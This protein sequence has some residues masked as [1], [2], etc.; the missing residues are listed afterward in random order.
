MHKHSPT[1]NVGHFFN[2]AAE[3]LGLS[4]EMRRTLINPYREITVEIPLRRN[5]GEL[6]LYTGYR[7]QHNNFRGPFKG[8]IRYHDTADLDDVR[9]LASLMTWKTA[10]TNLPLG[11]AKGGVTCNPRNLETNELERLTRT[12]TDKIALV[13]G[14]R[15]DIPAPDMGTDSQTMAWLM[16]EY[17][18][19]HGH[20]PE[21]VTGKP[22]GLNGSFGRTEATG[23]G[24]ALVIQQA[25]KDF[26]IVLIEDA[27][28]AI[29]GFGNVGLHT[30]RFLDEM[31]AKIVA[32]SD[33]AGG[34]YN[35][36]GLP[37]DLLADY[38]SQGR[39]VQE[40]GSA[41]TISNDE[42]LELSCDILVPAAVGG[43]ITEQNA[44]KIKARS[45]FEA[46]NGPITRSGENILEDKGKIIFPDILVNAG[47]VIVSY[48][49]WVQ[50]IQEFTWELEEVNDKLKRILINSYQQVCQLA[51]K[52]KVSMRTAAFMVGVE[53]VAEATRLRGYLN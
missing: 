47:G 40:F 18:K 9:A 51:E 36:N 5:D 39:L 35:P 34:I 3:K 14:P 7:V 31:G 38:P 49:E 21:T 48:F 16:D 33:Y 6:D 43:V 23:H 30:A 25:I 37:I 24:T 22:I 11:G 13:I 32:I 52:E 8:G 4:D 27:R 28:V 29:Q 10:L 26:N 1:E 2:Q 20:T 19:I 44:D 42:L 12:F 50:N 17:S 46:A 41:D 53:R 45:I 15:Q